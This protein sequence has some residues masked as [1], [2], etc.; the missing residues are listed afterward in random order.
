MVLINRVAYFSLEVLFCCDY[1]LFTYLFLASFSLL[2][3]RVTCNLPSYLSGCYGKFF[4]HILIPMHHCFSLYAGDSCPGKM[5]ATEDLDIYFCDIID[6]LIANGVELG[7]S[8]TC[9][10]H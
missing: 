9:N 2:R 1:N 7:Y 3:V 10:Q 8:V 5:R 6:F 4:P